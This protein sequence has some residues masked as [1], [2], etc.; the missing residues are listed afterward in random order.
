MFT[1]ALVFLNETHWSNQL[2][3][4]YCHILILHLAKCFRVLHLINPNND[5]TRSRLLFLFSQ[6]DFHGCLGIR[7]AS[8]NSHMPH[9]GL[10]SSFS[11]YFPQTTATPRPGLILDL[12]Y[13]SSLTIRRS[14]FNLH[15]STGPETLFV[16]LMQFKPH[17]PFWKHTLG[18]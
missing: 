1:W 6:S 7:L 12:S 18:R 8:H 2:I 13:H 11:E 10:P 14:F 9:L 5:L 17:T 15:P 3:F 16:A 4:H